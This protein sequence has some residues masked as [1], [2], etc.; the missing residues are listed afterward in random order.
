MSEM[1]GKRG[2]R[3]DQDRRRDSENDSGTDDE[4]VHRDFVLNYCEQLGTNELHK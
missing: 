4:Y 1:T 3:L 2:G